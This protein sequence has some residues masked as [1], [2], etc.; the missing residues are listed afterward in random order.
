MK[1]NFV[2]IKHCE[3][4]GKEKENSFYTI[5]DACFANLSQIC[6]SRFK[7]ETTK[8]LAKLLDEN[9]ILIVASKREAEHLQRRYPDW[10]DRIIPFKE[11]ETRLR[12]TRL[13]P[14]IDHGC[15]DYLRQLSAGFSNDELVRLLEFARSQ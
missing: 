5:C 11:W 15:Y 13:K 1:E 12:G 6:P 10:D 4:C 8:E 14:L 9:V 3:Q 7:G 2:I